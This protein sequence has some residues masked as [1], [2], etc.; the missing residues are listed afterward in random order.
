MEVITI[1]S[2]AFSKL[3]ANIEKLIESLNASNSKNEQLA[4]ANLTSAKNPSLD[5]QWLDN[6]QVCNLLRITKRTLQNYRD[7][8]ILPYSQVGKKMLYKK[9]D[10]IKLLEKHYF[11]IDNDV[12]LSRNIK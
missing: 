8:F 1:E 4:K 6:E 10:V 2:T 3:L 7:K 11:S 5:E 12:Q 9:D